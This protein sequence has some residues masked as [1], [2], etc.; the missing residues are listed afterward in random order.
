MCADKRSIELPE[1]IDVLRLAKANQS[2]SGKLDLA[3]MHR[4]SESL[5]KA[6]GRVNVKLNF[7]QGANGACYIQGEVRTDLPLICQR[8]TKP[9]QLNVNHQFTLA[10][11]RSE[12]MAEKLPDDVE[13]VLIPDDEKLCLSDMIED[14]LILQLP[15]IPKHTEVECSVKIEPDEPLGSEAKVDKQK[16]FANIIALKRK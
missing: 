15:I 7:S 8:C 10:P 12:A 3:K 1:Y 2:L 5:L 9:M 14:E 13:P 4:L 11:V 16:P 6:E